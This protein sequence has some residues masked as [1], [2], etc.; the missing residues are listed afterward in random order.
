MVTQAKQS[1]SRT[2]LSRD[3]VLHGAIELADREGLEAVT[4]RRLAEE[5]GVEAMSLYHHVA[6]KEALLDGVAE[7]VVQEIVEEVADLPLATDDED[8]RQALRAR[9]LGARG[10]MLRH[11][12]APVVLETRTTMNA[13]VLAYYH[14]LIE[15]MRVGGLSYDLIHHAMHTLGSRA[16]GFSQEMFNPAPNSDDEEMS[17]ELLAS[18]A[19]QLPLFVEFMEAIVHEDPEDQTLGW[20]DD[21]TEFEFAVDLMLDGLEARIGTSTVTGTR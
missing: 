8:W 18:M 9:I 1:E 7:T 21:Q 15:I 4:M 10:V 3:R 6:N 2:P 17:D 20:C 14:G 19:T 11:K 5:L 13:A 12:W 16:L